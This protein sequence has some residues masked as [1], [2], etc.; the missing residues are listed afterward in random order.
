MT[1]LFKE[2]VQIP[3]DEARW[4]ELRGWVYQL[5]ADFLSRPPRMSLIAEWRGRIEHRNTIPVCR[6][7]KKLK[8]YLESIPED[9][10]RRVCYEEADEFERLFSLQRG[11][12]TA[13]ESLYRSR[14]EGIDGLACLAEIRNEYEENGVVFNK[15]RGE[16]DDHIA[17]ELEFMAVLSEAMLSKAGLRE[18]C[19]RLADVQIGFL[20]SHLLKWAPVFSAE[21]A[22]AT[23]STLYGGMAELLEEFL[24]LDL[25]HLRIWRS[26]QG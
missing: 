1:M 25:E 9:N 23:T 11:G 18:S 15:I 13:C 4:L 19:L 20:E 6:S 8:S 7:G 24:K 12:I 10:L 26:L 16:R 21:L 17:L 3:E 2:P 22:A 5:I 14:G